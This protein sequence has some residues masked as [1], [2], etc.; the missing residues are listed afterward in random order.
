MSSK[1]CGCVFGVSA[2][3]TNIC[4]RLGVSNLR[5]HGGCADGMVG[6][7][8]HFK[9]NN[10]TDADTAYMMDMRDNLVHY[11]HLI[12][13]YAPCIVGHSAWNDKATMMRYCRGN[14]ALF[15]EFV[16]SISDEAFLLLVLLNYTATWMSEMTNEQ[17]KVSKVVCI[18]GGVLLVIIF[19]VC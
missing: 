3:A 13:I 11:V 19:Y 12:D 7:I 10:G 9:V 6:K 5:V 4:I 1:I 8:P 18:G 2:Q 15:N 16:L 17:A 14:A